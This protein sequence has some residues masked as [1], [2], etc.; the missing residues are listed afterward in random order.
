M[1]VRATVARIAEIDPS[2]AEASVVA[3]AVVTNVPAMPLTDWQL[4]QGA[5]EERSRCAICFAAV[6]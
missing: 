6:V 2:W 5:R 1:A 3:R 4:M